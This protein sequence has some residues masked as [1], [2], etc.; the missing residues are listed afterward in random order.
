[1]KFYLSND[2]IYDVAD[3]Y[4][5]K[6]STG[7]VKAGKSQ[8][9]AFSYIFKTGFSRSGKYVIALLDADGQVV[10]ADESNNNIIYGP[11]P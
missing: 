6:V 1:V 5:K 2:G 3:T 9:K 4:L 10:E 7:K 11:L 8:K